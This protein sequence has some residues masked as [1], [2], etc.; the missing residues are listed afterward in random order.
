MGEHLKLGIR[1]RVGKL[2][3]KVRGKEIELPEDKADISKQKNSLIEWALKAATTRIVLARN[4][5]E[6]SDQLKEVATDLGSGKDPEKIDGLR[7]AV[8]MKVGEV[9][10]SE[11]LNNA[12]LSIENLL[13]KGDVAGAVD[14]LKKLSKKDEYKV[15]A[16][17]KKEVDDLL[18]AVVEL[19][20]EKSKDENVLLQ[21]AN[22]VVVKRVE[23]GKSEEKEMLEITE[24]SGDIESE[25]A[26]RFVEGETNKLGP[27][28]NPKGNVELNIA[29][30]AEISKQAEMAIKGDDREVEE[31]KKFIKR[32]L[33]GGREGF[34]TTDSKGNLVI[35]V[36]QFEHIGAQLMYA[37]ASIALGR[38]RAELSK[39]ENRELREYLENLQFELRERL[40]DLEGKNKEKKA[41]KNLMPGLVEWDDLDPKVRE[42]VIHNADFIKN[43]PDAETLLRHTIDERARKNMG[44]PRSETM[45]RNL[46]AESNG[47]FKEN[48]HFKFENGEVYWLK[49]AES[50]FELCRREIYKIKD[51]VPEEQ[52]GQLMFVDKAQLYLALM[53]VSAKGQPEIRQAKDAVTKMLYME[54]ALKSLWKAGGN[55]E[56]WQRAAG[57]ILREGSDTNFFLTMKIREK[58]RGLDK[59]GKEVVMPGFNINDMLTIG[60]LRAPNGQS[61][62]AYISTDSIPVNQ[63]RLQELGSALTKMTLEKAKL[64][65]G[66]DGKRELSDAD[67]AK[68]LTLLNNKEI[69]FDKE[70]LDWVRNY[71]QYIH[72]A[73]LNVGEKLWLMDGKKPGSK[74]WEYA[75]LPGGQFAVKSGLWPVLYFSKY[76]VTKYGFEG[77]GNLFIPNPGLLSYARSET[78][79]HFMVVDGSDEKIANPD[80]SAVGS[81]MG[82]K[83]FFFG[84][85][86]LGEI[87]VGNEKVKKIKLFT[88]FWED[89]WLDERTGNSF[90]SKG[91]RSLQNSRD[92]GLKM[93]ADGRHKEFIADMEFGELERLIGHEIPGASKEDKLTWVVANLDYEMMEMKTMPS[94]REGDWVNKYSKLYVEAVKLFQDFLDS[95]TIANKMAIIATVAQYNNA[96]LDNL[97][98]KLDEFMAKKRNVNIGL[99]KGGNPLNP[100]D[101]FGPEVAD[102]DQKNLERTPDGDI[103]TMPMIRKSPTEGWYPGRGLKWSAEDFKEGKRNPMV[104]RKMEIQNEIAWGIVDNKTGGQM[105][106]DWQKMVYFGEQIT[107]GKLKIRPAMIP[108]LTPYFL[109]RGYWVDRMG[110]DW[111]DFKMIMSKQNEETWEKLKKL[112][113]I[114]I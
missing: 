48:E 32:V 18:D 104:M 34:G 99:K 106:R 10:D 92:V 87:T 15:E 1:E 97:S 51:S 72:T 63:S 68:Y 70:Q 8:M 19:D 16:K 89:V 12:Q 11:E 31:D 114:E 26:R 90:K 105:M 52:L 83:D 7:A 36:D 49:D 76:Q 62:L 78:L 96:T 5:G 109:M 100:L 64:R 98:T 73:T 50:F 27:K 108:F 60:E 110:L 53:G 112:M 25:V 44:M 59:E 35:E 69:T 23:L 47:L 39:P 3:E 46:I 28:K 107:I 33:S 84:G 14:W 65:I 20:K 61:W 91:M 38:N 41:G 102:S 95:P 58:I 94:K 21:K 67:Y 17:K 4:V 66:K 2:A 30:V 55:H 80:G 82:A 113:G 75:S 101:Y 77:L 79:R 6:L 43:N 103:M 111:E 9:V 81:G 13:K 71:M 37:R 86:D 85:R 22:E 45:I 88:N 93:I 40:F 57:L 74:G 54:F 29:E 24:V 56:A 42:T